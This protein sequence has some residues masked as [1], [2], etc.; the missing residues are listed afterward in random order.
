MRVF[1]YCRVS[2][3]SQTEGYSLDEQKER[4]EAYCKALG[5]ELV[6]VFV[7]GGESGAKIDRPA[8][9]KMCERVKEVNKVVVYKLDRLSRSQKDT[10]FLIEDVF[11]KNGVDF[12]SITEN[13]D[14]STPFGKAMV[15]ILAVFAQL[16]REHKW[17]RN[18]EVG[19]KGAWHIHLVINRIPDTDEIIDEAWGHGMTDFKHIRKMGDMEK[20]ASYITKSPRTE[21]RLKESSYSSSRNLP[22]PKPETKVIMRWPTWQEPIVKKGWYL[23]KESMHEGINPVTG[24][25]YRTYTLLRLK[26][27]ESETGDCIHIRGS[28]R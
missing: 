17:I 26:G 2:T 1:G 22:I 6:K 16:E 7:D 5:W 10:L 27:G 23:D 21:K 8:L 28:G 9:Q 25:R 12:V 20:I 11:L 3:A 14:T 4:I 18:I 24:Y 19:T 13:F 15:G